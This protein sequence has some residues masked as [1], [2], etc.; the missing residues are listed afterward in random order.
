[1]FTIHLNKLAFFAH[2]GLHDEEAITGTSFEIDVSIQFDAKGKINSLHQTINYAAAYEVIKKHMLHPVALLESL[3]QD[4]TE[5]IY[6]LD[7]RITVIKIDI[8]KLHPPIKNF[9]GS[10]GVSYSKVF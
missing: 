9:I 5:D 7:N 6:L 8:N 3:A 2:H 1:M 4:I 10:V